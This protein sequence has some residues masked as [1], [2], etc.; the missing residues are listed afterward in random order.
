MVY[1]AIFSTVIFCIS[2]ENISPIFPVSY[3]VKYL[4]TP[5]YIDPTLKVEAVTFTRE[6]L[7]CAFIE[8]FATHFIFMNGGFVYIY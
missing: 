3:L 4:I 7:L 5:Y 2:L 8:Y 1:V 6:H